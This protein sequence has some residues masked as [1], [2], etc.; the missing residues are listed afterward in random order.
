MKVK[1]IWRSI[2]PFQ[3]RIEDLGRVSEAELPEE[4]DFKNIEV[5][6][7]DATPIGYFLF[8]IDMPGYTMQYGYCDITNKKKI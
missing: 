2:N 3:P 6:A 4:T 1:V 7:I 8:K 5:F